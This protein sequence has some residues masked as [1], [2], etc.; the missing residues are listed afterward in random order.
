MPEQQVILRDPRFW[1]VTFAE[2]LGQIGPHPDRDVIYP[3]FGLREEDAQNWFTQTMKWD[4]VDV[5]V[6]DIGVDPPVITRIP[7]ANAVELSIEWN[8]GDIDWYLRAPDL[9]EARFANIGGHWLLPGLRLREA[10]AIAAA[11]PEPRWRVTLL[12]L[13][14]VWLTEGDNADLAK[15]A[16]TSAWRASK[17]VPPEKAPLLADLWVEAVEEADDY[18]WR[19]SPA[20]WICDAENSPRA[21]HR[22]PAEI[23]RINQLIARAS[24][25]SI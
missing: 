9:G 18:L 14:V 1:A 17:L 16:I 12:L 15:K 8:L 21:E 3:L 5:R 19:N 25:S 7:L 13:L 22:D 6:S 10:L 20:G 23:A 4:A 24:T 2:L 11:A